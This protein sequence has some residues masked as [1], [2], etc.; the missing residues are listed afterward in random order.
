[1]N[2][3]VISFKDI[4]VSKGVTEL[5]EMYEGQNPTVHLPVLKTDSNF[6]QSVIRACIDNGIKVVAYFVTADGLDH[7]LKQADDISVADN[8]VKE[9]LHH[10]GQGDAVSMVWD[11]SP[12][13]HFAL[14]MVEDLALDMWDITDGVEAI[15][16][17]SLLEDFMNM[18][19]EELHDEMHSA[20]GYFLDLMAT[21]VGNMVIESI[22]EAVAERLRDENGKKDINPFEQD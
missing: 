22:S 18:S 16:A 5:L 13:L 14:H 7:I 8:P 21:F 20:L 9:V 2:L 4:D 1:M 19:Q 6:A 11:D 12:Q 15:D 3:A 17:E 10:M